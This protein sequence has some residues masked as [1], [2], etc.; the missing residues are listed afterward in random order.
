M[1]LDKGAWLVKIEDGFCSLSGTYPKQA[2]LTAERI[3][4]SGFAKANPTAALH[5]FK[6]L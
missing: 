6:S 5:L 4:A 1:F 2:A 3:N